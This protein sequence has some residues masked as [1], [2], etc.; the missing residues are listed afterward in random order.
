MC[1]SSEISGSGISPANVHKSQ[2][3]FRQSKAVN[4]ELSKN[5]IFT[6]VNGHNYIAGNTSHEAMLKHLKVFKIFCTFVI[7]SI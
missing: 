4:Y 1:E 2:Y 3:N 7:I 5:F 6:T